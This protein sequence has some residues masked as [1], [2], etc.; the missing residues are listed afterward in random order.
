MNKAA[1]PSHPAFSHVGTTRGTRYTH[2][3]RLLYILISL[4]AVLISPK[5]PKTWSVMAATRLFKRGENIADVNW[6][7]HVLL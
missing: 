7:L 6:D 1:L 3:F 5:G 4:T 2:P